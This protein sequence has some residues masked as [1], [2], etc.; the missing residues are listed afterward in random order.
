MAAGQENPKGDF[1]GDQ[2]KKTLK[3]ADTTLATTAT[4]LPLQKDTT[5]EATEFLLVGDHPVLCLLPKR[6]NG[7]VNGAHQTSPQVNDVHQEQIDSA[8]QN[9]GKPTN[10]REIQSSNLGNP[11]N[12][13]ESSGWTLVQRKK[14]R[15]QSS[16]FKR[17]WTNPQS[18]LQ[19]HAK[20]LRQQQRCFK[21]LLKGHVQAVCAN[22]RRCLNCNKAGHVIRSCPLLMTGKPNVALTNP[23]LYKTE[24]PHQNNNT[25]PHHNKEIPPVPPVQTPIP[26]V[27]TPIPPVLKPRT[28]ATQPFM[29]MPRNPHMDAP[30]N[31]MTMPMRSPAELWQRR[32][33]S[34]NVYLAPREGLAPANRFL[35]NAAFVFAGPGASDP[36]V[37]RFGYPLR[38]APYFTNGNYE[39]LTMLIATKSPEE[40][41]FHLQFIVNP[42]EKEV[43]VEIDGWLM[44]ERPPPPN[45]RRS[46]AGDGRGGQQRGM[47]RRGPSNYDGGRHRGNDG[48]RDHRDDMALSSSGSNRTRSAQAW[49]Q[50]WLQNLKRALIEV[51][52]LKETPQEEQQKERSEQMQIIEYVPPLTTPVLIVPSKIVM[53]LD[54]A[55]VL[56]DSGLSLFN[57]NL[58]RPDI[59]LP[60]QTVFNGL[61]FFSGPLFAKI[62]HMVHGRE[63]Q[64]CN[65]NGLGKEYNTNQTLVLTELNSVHENEA[66]V[67]D[68]IQGPPPGFE[69]PIYKNDTIEGNTEGPPPGFELPIYRLSPTIKEVKKKTRCA[70]ESLKVRRSPRLEKKYRE[71]G[72]KIGAGKTNRGRKPAKVKMVKMDYQESLSPLSMTQAGMVIK[73]AGVEVKGTIEDEV[74]KVVMV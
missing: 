52:I 55:K 42:Y 4:G 22:P 6:D 19:L 74:A 50:D 62:C 26:P 27:Q 45:Q 23:L 12:N 47:G 9:N 8:S 66:H 39:Y 67:I 59:Q 25:L 60:H 61:K 20:K 32:P 49:M 71:G 10:S 36:A 34:L 38:V 64:I 48:N 72:K 68:D 35:E 33:H 58:L 18:K 1:N 13:E 73:L 53:T 3:T 41:P 40:I 21:C 44:N 24:P 5:L 15:E 37:K 16:K 17:P 54:R 46:T 69:L 14:R 11:N 63:I 65:D 51:G 70:N 2:E 43:R 56:A 57:F 28:T 29:E 7:T 30:R 31:W